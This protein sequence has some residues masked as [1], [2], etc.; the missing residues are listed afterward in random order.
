MIHDLILR[1]G[2][3]GLFVL[4][5]SECGLAIVTKRGPW[6]MAVSHWWHLVMAVAMAAMAWPWGARLPTTGPAVFFLLGTVWFMAVAVAAAR[7]V[8]VFALYGYHGLMMLATA[9]MYVIMDPRLS[10]TGPA[11]SMPGMDMDAAHVSSTGPPVWFNAANWL[12][13]AGFAVAAVLWTYSYFSQRQH[14][15]T[16]CSLGN[17]GQAMMAAGMSILF[18]A[19]LFRI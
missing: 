7:T 1:W 5:A 4:A 13:A 6:T 14:K 19:A 3:T 10:G 16:R 9:W 15:A 2:V 18:V 11:T 17:L 8:A 12:G